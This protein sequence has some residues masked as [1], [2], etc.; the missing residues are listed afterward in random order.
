M[1][2][3][4]CLGNGG[5]GGDGAEGGAARKGGVGPS[6]GHGVT[7]PGCWVNGSD[8]LIYTQRRKRRRADEGVNCFVWLISL[9]EKQEAACTDFEEEWS[10]PVGRDP[11]TWP[12]WGWWAWKNNTLNKFK[13][14][15]DA[16]QWVRKRV[17]QAEKSHSPWFVHDLPQ[18]SDSVV[19]THVL[20]VDVVHLEG[21]RM[22][23]KGC[24]N[25]FEGLALNGESQLQW[26]CNM[27]K[28]EGWFGWLASGTKQS[29]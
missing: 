13:G 15:Y 2:L 3:T 25:S 6:H 18:N 10:N 14:T 5:G 16:Q 1:V 29:R 24:C 19:V 22:K 26:C 28:R 8:R 11:N 21:E 12:Q 7:H 23:V 27:T 4:F 20:K 17:Q 9:R